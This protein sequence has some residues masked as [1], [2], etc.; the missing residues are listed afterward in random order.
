VPQPSSPALPCPAHSQLACAPSFSSFA[1]ALLMGRVLLLVVA[2]AYH[3]LYYLDY[4][5]D[6][7]SD[8]YADWFT[9]GINP[10]DPPGTFKG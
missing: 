9:Y 8:H 3:D 6:F 10:K 4:F 7:Y 5:V 1:A 2:P